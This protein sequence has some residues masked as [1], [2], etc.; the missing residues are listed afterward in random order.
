MGREKETH[1]LLVRLVDGIHCILD[2]H[3]LH[4]PRRHLHPQREVQVNLLDRGGRQ[5]LLEDG[6]LVDG[7][8]RRV[9]LPVQ[10]WC[11]V[12]ACPCVAAGNELEPG[13]S[14]RSG[15]TAGRGAILPA[16]FLRLL[17]DLQL[18]SILLCRALVSLCVA[19]SLR[20]V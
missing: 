6:R 12:S 1:P 14:R 13:R 4:V 18:N 11:R 17:R 16:S 10:T 19:R 20:G 15:G 2:G 3:A 5:Q 8:G 7:A 9:D